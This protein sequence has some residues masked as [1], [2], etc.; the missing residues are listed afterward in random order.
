[1]LAFVISFGLTTGLTGTFQCDA[2]SILSARG[3]IHGSS[4]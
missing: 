2:G 3:K 1:M 4:G